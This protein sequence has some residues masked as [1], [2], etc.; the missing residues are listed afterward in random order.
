MSIVYNPQIRIWWISTR[1]GSMTSGG[2]DITPALGD[3]SVVTATKSTRLEMGS[4]TLRYA[5]QPL[6]N[7]VT[8]SIFDT[9]YALMQPMDMIEIRMCHSPTDMLGP[10]LP[11]LIMRG[12][13]SK[14][15]RSEAIPGGRPQRWL[16]VIGHDMM[17]IMHIL[18]LRPYYGL[19]ADS[20]YNLSFPNESVW[21]P[22]MSLRNTNAAA[23][24]NN[25]V[26]F[27]VN[28]YM[29]GITA[30]GDTTGEWANWTVST[31]VLGQTNA[32]LIEGPES[33][34]SLY[35]LSKQVLDVGIFNE[36]YTDDTEMGTVLVNRPIP[37]KTPVAG[38]NGGTF[39]QTGAYAATMDIPSVDILSLT[40]ERSDEDAANYFWPDLDRNTWQSFNT[41]T[42]VAVLD[43]AALD[44]TMSI[45]TPKSIYGTRVMQE[46]VNLG[47]PDGIIMGDSHSPLMADSKARSALTVN[48]IT[49]RAIILADMNQD[50]TVFETGQI[51]LRGRHDVRHGMYLNL[52]RGP[53]QIWDQMCY[54]HSVTHEFSTFGGYKTFVQYDRG[55]N[56]ISRAGGNPEFY[57]HEI[58]AHSI[59]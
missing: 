9:I 57:I 46:T 34:G 28:P 44:R 21:H 52:Y 50:N 7:L 48:W 27:N 25:V 1:P 13:V 35:A 36:L 26:D 15:T 53:N 41:Q 45:N 31:N 38:A 22:G 40:M 42:D 30:L 4:F 12:L 10:G 3:N 59:R 29:A 32:T 58:E 23:Y 24:L 14:I 39:I 43:L 2:V 33:G 47:D 51:V 16:N 17:K 8:G 5:D 18:S 11:P 6:V 49:M 20:D 56:W 55:T 19:P 54:A 37:F